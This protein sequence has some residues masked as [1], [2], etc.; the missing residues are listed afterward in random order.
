M[1]YGGFLLRCT[2][3]AT[4]TTQGSF[5]LFA[6]YRRLTHRAMLWKGHTLKAGHAML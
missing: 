3:Q 5:T 4:H 6:L 1:L 2:D